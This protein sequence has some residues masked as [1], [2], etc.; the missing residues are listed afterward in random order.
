MP[1]AII[2]DRF[3]EAI[4]TGIVTSAQLLKLFLMINI[5]SLVCLCIRLV[6]V[7]SEQG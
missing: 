2:Y 1:L 5:Q 6:K 4:G 3:I 7:L